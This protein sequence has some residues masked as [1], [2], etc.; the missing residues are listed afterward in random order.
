LKIKTEKVRENMISI[1]KKGVHLGILVILLTLITYPGSAVDFSFEEDFNDPNMDN[2]TLQGTDWKSFG[3]VSTNHTFSISSDELISGGASSG[4]KLN[5]AYI[6][7]NTS[8]G[9][10]SIDVLVPTGT[11]THIITNRIWGLLFSEIQ[12][13]RY[14]NQPN[15]TKYPEFGINF[16]KGSGNFYAYAGTPGILIDELISVS[17]QKF[18]QK[19]HY[20]FIRTN[21]RFYVFIDNEMALNTS[22]SSTIGDSINY[23]TIA[24]AQGSNVTFDNLKITKD[25][26]GIL[27]DI[28]TSP[29]APGFSIFSMFLIATLSTILIRKRKDSQ[30]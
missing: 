20:D 30:F 19:Q 6:K 15:S 8:I 16:R 18:D 4:S 9:G 29:T 13:S 27:N 28:P 14:E 5:G 24:A 23:F 21:E 17:N 1:I 22:L 26:N 2:W 7:D 3:I 10:W 25:A 12:M 11:Q